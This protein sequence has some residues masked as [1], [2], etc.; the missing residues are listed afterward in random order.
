MWLKKLCMLNKMSLLFDSAQ[1][2]TVTQIKQMDTSKNTELSQYT[3]KQHM[4]LHILTHFHVIGFFLLIHMLNWYVA[5]WQS[6][7][8]IWSW[9]IYHTSPPYKPPSG[10][11]M[12]IHGDFKLNT[13]LPTLL[14]QDILIGLHTNGF[15]LPYSHRLRQYSKTLYLM[16]LGDRDLQRKYVLCPWA[17][18]VRHRRQIKHRSSLRIGH[19]LKPVK[20]SDCDVRSVDCFCF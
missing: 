2:Q 8:P 13:F 16:F 5:G 15:S 7:C 11:K 12:Q 17:R 3:Q 18:D 14:L 4:M 6:S 10:S 20:Q 1:I 19:K 9:G